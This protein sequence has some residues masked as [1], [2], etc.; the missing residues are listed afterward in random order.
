MGERQAQFTERKQGLSLTG[1]PLLMTKP[2]PAS[3]VASITLGDRS[4]AVQGTGAWGLQSAVQAPVRSADPV[5][6]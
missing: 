1:F 6:K 2:L 4:A 5:L 3:Q